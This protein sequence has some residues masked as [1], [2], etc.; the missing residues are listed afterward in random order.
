MTI[1]ITTTTLILA[2]I[3]LAAAVVTPMLNPFLR[4]PR[5]VEREGTPDVPPRFSVVLTVHDNAEQISR[6]LPMLLNQQ[7][8]GFEVIVVDESSNDDTADQLKLLKASNPH[9]YTTF[10]PESSHYL[11]RRK[12]A[13]TLGVKA[14][15]NEWVVFTDIDCVP[16]SP[17]WLQTLARYTEQADIVC[18][19]TGYTDDTPAYWRFLRLQDN[20][21]LLG[22][23][24]R[25]EGNC[26]AFKKQMFISQ[27]GFLRNLRFL[28][29]EYDFLVNENY[30]TTIAVMTEANGRMH[31]Q[32]PS[33]KSWTDK[34]LCFMETRRH[35]SHTLPS[36]LLA[37]VDQ[38]ALHL[39][40]CLQAGAV[41]YAATMAD[42]A[43]MAAAI[44]CI[45]L[46]TAIRLI[47]ARSAMQAFDETIAL[48][49]VPF[50]EL[51]R[52][53]TTTGLWLRH[54]RADKYDFIRK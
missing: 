31:Q 48:W 1:T 40:L 30:D 38:A 46:T 47:V 35:L 12:L 17:L 18:G 8:E 36:R 37:F 13:L 14:A 27:N 45:I 21:T 42:W 50:F 33:N 29:G 24:Y 25:Y 19:Y 9:L 20:C 15:K 39:N 7:Y 28:R 11:S 32:Q 10:I 3:L 53:W 23:P 26:L 49:K 43:L 4:K 44:F 41:A 34:Q 51:R 52:A 54:R 16:D 5:R 22:R 2:A 6:N